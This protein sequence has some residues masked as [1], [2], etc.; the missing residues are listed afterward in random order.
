MK[1]TFGFKHAFK[2]YQFQNAHTGFK[3]Y[4]LS[5]WCTKMCVVNL[6]KLYLSPKEWINHLVPLLQIG[7]TF[8]IVRVWV[9]IVFD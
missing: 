8:I 3:R 9:D 2:K 6:K 7:F 1:I 5:I 4:E